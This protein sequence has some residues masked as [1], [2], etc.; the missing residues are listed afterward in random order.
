[1]PDYDLSE[2][3]R[4]K[5]TVYGK[6]LD[7]KYSQLLFEKTDLSLE[8]V[9]LLDRVQKNIQISKEQSDM[10]RKTKLVEGRYP[11]IY[12]SKGISEIIDDKVGYT[13]KSA[14]DDR[15][16]KDFVLKHIENFGKI[17]KKELDE[18]LIDKL[19]SNLSLTQKRTKI[20]Y[21]VNVSLQKKENKIKNIGTTRYPIWAKKDSN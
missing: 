5:V 20:K 17:T 3:E 15:Y 14:F 7:E 16:Y 21:L 12:V 1:M 4:V 11:N 6:I 13:K 9:M 19:P 18:L 8:Q 10:L 2:N